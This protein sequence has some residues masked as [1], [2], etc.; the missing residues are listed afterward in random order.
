[1]VEPMAKASD[2]Q[3]RARSNQVLVGARVSK[4]FHRR[5]HAESIRRDQS[6]QDLVTNALK[7]YFD[8]P[9]GDWKVANI[10]YHRNDPDLSE[11][12]AKEFNAWIGVWERYLKQMPREKID[13]LAKA[14]EWDLLTQKSSRRKMVEKGHGQRPAE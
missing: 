1:M 10:T 14:M 12:D 7:L 5:I 2:V 4:S 8:T 13:V 9:V 6:V 11:A 3:K